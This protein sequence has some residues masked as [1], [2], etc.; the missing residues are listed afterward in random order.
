MPGIPASRLFSVDPQDWAAAG[1][2]AAPV[3]LTGQE[4]AT[5]VVNLAPIEELMDAWSASARRTW[6]KHLGEYRFSEG[7]STA[8]LIALVEAG[9]ARHGRR[10]PLSAS[11]L[12]SWSRSLMHAGLGTLYTLAE[13]SKLAAGILVLRG[14]VRAFYWLAGSLPGPAMTVLLGHVFEH[15]HQQ[16]VPSFDFMGANTP[17]ISEFKRRFGGAR[18]IYP[19]WVRR[20]TVSSLLERAARIRRGWRR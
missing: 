19:H 14:P 7:G 6:R 4:K 5:W 13:G 17:G 2:P 16:G 3:G 8:D 15:L 20:T 9:Y 11:A 18:V 12:Q 10:L 1:R